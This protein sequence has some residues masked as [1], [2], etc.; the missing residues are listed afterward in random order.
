MKLVAGSNKVRG[1]KKRK[2]AKNHATRNAATAL[3][4]NRRRCWLTSLSSGP[5]DAIPPAAAALEVP[6]AGVPTYVLDVPGGHGKVPIGPTYLG[7]DPGALLI[8]DA[9]GGQHH[10]PR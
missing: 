5:I 10:Y 2:K 6:T 3:H 8:E 7:D 9:F 4:T 1:R